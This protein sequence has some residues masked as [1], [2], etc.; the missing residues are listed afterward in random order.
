[1]PFI[2]FNDPLYNLQGGA[3]PGSIGTQS[4]ARANVT[5]GGT[6]GGDGSANADSAKVGGP[7]AGTYFVAFGEDA[8][9]TFTNRGLR[10]L[11]QNTDAIDNILRGSLPRVERDTIVVGTATA[12]ISLGGDVFVGPSGTLNTQDAINRLVYLENSDGSV[13]WVSGQIPLCSLIHN[14]AGVNVLGTAADG[15]Y[16]NPTLCFPVLI[17]PG[18]YTLFVGR[19]TSYANLLEARAGDWVAEHLLG[20]AYDSNLWKHFSHGLNE[21]YRKS[22]ART[23]GGAEDNDTPGSGSTIYRDGPSVSIIA[24]NHAWEAAPSAFDD[25]LRAQFTTAPLAGWYL[26]SAG[27]TNFDYTISG[28]TGHVHITTRRTSGGGT[29]RGPS[30]RDVAA[31]LVVN[32]VDLAANEV[33]SD[34]YFTYLAVRTPAT[35]NPGSTGSSYVAVNA[36]YYFSESGKTGIAF[37]IDI[38]LVERL[39]GAVLTRMPYLVYSLPNA[40]TAELMPLGGDTN[41]PV[42][43]F[44]PNTSCYVTWL[45][46]VD[47]VGGAT[48]N[49]PQLGPMPQSGMAYAPFMHISPARNR[50]GT[51]DSGM[52]ELASGFYGSAL[53]NTPVFAVGSFYY[54]GNLSPQFTI[55]SNGNIANSGIITSALRERTIAATMS[56]TMTWNIDLWN[57]P[58]SV[59]FDATT[60]VG[61]TELTITTVG[62][63]A[64]WALT[65]GDSFTFYIKSN[66]SAFTLNTP[67]NWV[68]SRGDNVIAD[69]LGLVY[70]FVCRVAPDGIVRITRTDFE[71]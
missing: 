43:T 18:T 24:E 32:P 48:T 66:G 64:N 55:C 8:T 36:P 11:T 62:A 31:T 46:V 65:P 37:G 28:S 30:I 10:A 2:R 17:P 42:P 12:N 67:S 27:Y 61:I 44:A 7:N 1:M 50:A 69:L 39:D 26:G 59:L 58:S 25:P 71:R 38:L 21:K 33:G 53:N 63:T 56:T 40:V 35:L 41:S 47:V 45:Q 54:T 5:N 15:F 60:V 14:G 22:T 19:R 13:L 52:Q 23:G 4:Y 49:Q 70:M 16:T 29:E 6:G 20:R 34:P 9:S 57:G 51:P 68:F 3:Y